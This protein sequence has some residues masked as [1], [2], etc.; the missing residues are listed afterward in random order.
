MSRDTF[1]GAN[2][3]L[4]NHISSKPSTR[5]HAPPGGA[6]SISLGWGDAPAPAPA[7]RSV[8][9]H[10]PEAAPASYGAPAH[11]SRHAMTTS[12]S[13]SGAAASMYGAPA[14]FSGATSASAYGTSA[15]AYGTSAS[16]YGA[17]P[18]ASSGPTGYGA[19]KPSGEVHRVSSNAYAS[20]A[21]QNCGNVLTDRPTTLVAAPPGGRSSI[22][23]G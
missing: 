8:A 2:Q 18:V 11:S 13:G 20:G 17:A 6:S 7:H 3:N 15:S 22:V 12:L 9:R 23:L 21:N 14:P 4:G 19:P 5:L 10:E 1:M 16:A